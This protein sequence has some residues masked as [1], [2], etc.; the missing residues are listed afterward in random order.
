MIK[1]NNTTVRAMNIFLKI[2]LVIIFVGLYMAVA[3]R[4]IDHAILFT[5]IVNLFFGLFALICSILII[6]S[7][8]SK[9]KKHKKVT[10]LLPTITISI[11]AIALITTLIK[12]S[13]R[14]NAPE[15]FRFGSRMND[16]SGTFV[17]LR[18]DSTYKVTDWCMGADY[19]RGKY[20]VNNGVISLDKNLSCLRSSIFK[21][22]A[23]TLKDGTIDTVIYPLDDYGDKIGQY[24][25]SFRIITLNNT[26]D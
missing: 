24:S 20:S 19:Y 9:F 12:L 7:D 5:G 6:R 3:I 25:S 11:M 23:D 14:D 4:T 17:S 10:E 8:V 15:V 22:E 16:I 13:Q 2:V 21:I 26:N 18:S 1:E